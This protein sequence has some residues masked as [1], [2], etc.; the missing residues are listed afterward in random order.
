MKKNEVSPLTGG[1]F[2]LVK[3]VPVLPQGPFEGPLRQA[4]NHLNQIFWNNRRGNR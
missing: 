3:V 1:Y 4:R 2:D